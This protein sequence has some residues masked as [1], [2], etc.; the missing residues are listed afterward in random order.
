MIKGSAG[1]AAAAA[2]AACQPSVTEVT[3]IV[4]REVEKQVTVVVEKEVEKQGELVLRY[5]TQLWNWQKLNMATATDQYN[6]D[7]RGK[8]R[9]EVDPVPDGWQ[10]KVVQMIKGD[11][12]QWDGMLRTRNLGEIRDY[13][14]MGI[15]QPWD[16]FINASSVPWASNF[17]DELLPNIRESF[18]EEGKLYG[19]PWDIELYCR[20]YMKQDWDKLGEVPAETLEDF[21]N[22]LREMKK[23]FPDKVPFGFNHWCT[24]PPE[25][26]WCQLWDDDPWVREEGMGSFFDVRG[27]AYK[28]MLLMWERWYQEGLITDDS[29]GGTWA[30]LMLKGK[31]TCVQTGAAWAQARQQKIYGRANVVPMTNFVLN[32]GDTPKTFTF[33]NGAILF[34]GAKNPQGITDWLLWMLDPTVEKIA[35]H[36]FHKGDL[37]YYH[38]P[39][40]K[41]IYENLIPQNPDWVWM[42]DMLEMVSASST[43]PTDAHL[44]IY[45]PIACAWHEKFLHGEASLDECVDAI[46]EEER[47]ATKEMLAGLK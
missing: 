2:L 32:E 1:A 17:W 20:V 33:G 45:G 43:V 34:N 19:L 38:L 36:S 35:N 26:M 40:Y 6:M 14:R 21:E 42:Q 4:E 15:I 9:V 25:Q 3:K 11:E 46:Y 12:L 24:H 27:D 31:L 13:L 16:A 8:V 22:Q 5:V 23:I 44:N 29:I 30:D 37:N 7:N 41:S 47:E 28:Q 10:T 39:A 18:S